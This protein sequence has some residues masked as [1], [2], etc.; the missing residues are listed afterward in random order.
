MATIR[1]RVLDKELRPRKRDRSRGYLYGHWHEDIPLLCCKFSYA[2][3]CTMASFSRDGE[4]IA[5]VLKVLGYRIVRGTSRKGW[6]EA[7]NEMIKA[8]KEKWDLV[9]AVDG[10]K[11][12]R[13]EVK[14][15]IIYLSK[16]AGVHIVPVVAN[17]KYKI[18]FSRSWDRMWVPLPFSPAV[19]VSGD[20]IFVAKD[21]SEMAFEQKRKE[22]EEAL[23]SLKQKAVAYY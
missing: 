15:G 23:H 12:P 3:L 14:P 11:G 1:T 13:Y 17:A 19:L 18:V 21:S 5:N 22:V 4:V 20:P 7:F 2:R 10:P 9:L 16:E 8:V 6:R